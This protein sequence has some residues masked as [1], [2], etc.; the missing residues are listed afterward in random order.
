MLD[1]CIVAGVSVL[2]LGGCLAY[3]SENDIFS[4]E[5]INKFQRLIYVS[6]F[7]IAIDCTFALLEGT[8]FNSFVLY[9]IKAVELTLNPVLAFLVFEI[10]Y[11]K[12]ASHKDTVS[13]NRMRLIILL[14]ITLNGILQIT[15]IFKGY[16]FFL[17]S[18]NLYHRGSLISVY[19]LLLSASVIT[20]MYGMI[21]FSRKAQSTMR[22]TLL[23][24]AAILAT[25]IIIRNFFP[26]KNYDFLCISVAMPFLLIYYSHITLSLDPLTKLLNRQIYHN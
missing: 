7:A 20:L 4:I 16:I 23:S 2:F 18:N 11:D 9:L 12:K 24:F 22:A 6:M 26:K 5:D 10:F 15:T 1:Y 8:K 14:I 25:G 19:I 13:L 21:I 17:D 3:L